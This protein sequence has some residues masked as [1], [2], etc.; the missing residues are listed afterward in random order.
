MDLRIR[1]RSSDDTVT[2]RTITVIEIAPP[3]AVNAL[4]HLRGEERTFVL[5]RIEEAVDQSTGE[6][7]ADVWQ[8]FGLT[9]RKR[10]EPTMPVFVEKV[11]PL[12]TQAG[13]N[14]RKAD[15][16]ALFRVFVVEAIKVAKKR[17]LWNIFDGRCFRC[18]STGPL[19]MDHHVPQHL[20][21]R[22]V[23]GNVVL[24]CTPCNSVKRTAHPFTFYSPPQLAALAPKLQAELELFD[25]TFS[26]TRWI[27]HP[28]EYLVF[29]GVTE[30]QAVE[31]LRARDADRDEWPDMPPE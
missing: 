24:L 13:Q 31:A 6:V 12:S 9:S 8:H 18:G 3:N 29:V 10:P 7:I 16:A 28:R 5:D 30:E 25:F 11:S 2:E 15:K 1:Y 26:W 22:L 19:D 23:A 27:N 20:G 17:Q 4:C 21:G 14:Q